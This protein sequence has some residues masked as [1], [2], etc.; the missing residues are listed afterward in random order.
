MDIVITKPIEKPVEKS[1]EIPKKIETESIFKQPEAP[2]EVKPPAPIQA[3]QKAKVSTL[4]ADSDDEE[5]E[6][7]NK[8]AESE[9][10]KEV[11]EV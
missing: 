11:V 7:V 10:K 1:V 5:E 3:Q 4:F 6:E 2:V 8:P 9:T